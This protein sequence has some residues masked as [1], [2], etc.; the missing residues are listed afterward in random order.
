MESGDIAGAIAAAER[1]TQ[2][3]PQDPRGFYTLGTLLS[4]TGDWEGAQTALVE[5]VSMSA[6]HGAAHNNLGLVRMQLREYQK[7]SASFSR[8]AKLLKRDPGPLVNLAAALAFR[9]AHGAAV[10]AYDEAIMRAPNNPE[11]RVAAAT[12]MARA[13]QTAEALATFKSLAADKAATEKYALQIEVGLATVLRQLGRFDIALKHADK[14]VT[15][16]PK[17]A[18]ALLAAG[19]VRDY[20]GDHKGAEAH[21]KRALA[22]SANNLDV[23]YNYAVFLEEQGRTDDAKDMLGKYVELCTEESA[24][25]GHARGRLKRLGKPKS[26][27]L[28]TAP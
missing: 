27:P 22:A 4:R 24:R 20:K 16:G 11:L 13:N 10:D 26:P 28:Q 2:T 21:Y 5:C 6:G 17:N 19:L 12:A 14:A 8:A 1:H 23:M 25:C 9:G 7:A 3:H 15:L 18:Q